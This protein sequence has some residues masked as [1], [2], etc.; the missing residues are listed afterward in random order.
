MA[1]NN[2]NDNAPED[3]SVVLAKMVKS[4][5]TMIAQ[6]AAKLTNDTRAQEFAARVSLLTKTEPKFIQAIEQAPDT[7]LSAMMA[8]V[9]LDLMPNTPEQH[10]FIIPFNNRQKNRM[11]VQ[12]QVGYKGLKE[13]ALRSGEVLTL[14]A[15][16]VFKGDTFD[17]ELGTE[18]KLIHKPNFDVDRTDYKLVT[19]AYATAKLHNGEH[20]FIVM[21]RKEL[22]KIQQT[23]QA[24]STDAPWNKWPEAQAMKTVIKKFTKLLPS[25][26]K[27]NRLALAAELDS[28]AEGNNLMVD[29]NGQI[30]DK[31]ITL[32]ALSDDEKA[33]LQQD[34]KDIAAKRAAAAD[35]GPVTEGVVIDGPTE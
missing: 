5:A 32:P 3:R 27:D 9:H 15:E 21:T 26:S 34:A 31:K 8:C 13:L 22:D 12:F 2:T 35:R 25:S 28:R 4:E 29:E 23:A 20:T 17:V 18:R 16:L 33:K 6:Y 11:E 7:F 14:N 30:K 24:K 19:H 1:D 10:A